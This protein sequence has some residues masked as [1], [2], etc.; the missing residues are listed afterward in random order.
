M[1]VRSLLISATCLLGLAMG[2]A[3]TL[4]AD[5]GTTIPQPQASA[6]PWAPS[7]EWLE[8]YEWDAEVRALLD[9]SLDE[10]DRERQLDLYD[11]YRA[12]KVE[13]E[14]Y[15]VHNPGADAPCATRVRYAQPQQWCSAQQN[16]LEQLFQSL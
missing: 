5:G 9:A 14:D 3:C 4:P 7:D 13:L 10:E 6:T 15:F 11:Q 8:L 2:A 16:E 1:S 12:A